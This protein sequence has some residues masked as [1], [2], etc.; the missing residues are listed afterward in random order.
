MEGI[1]V[2]CEPFIGLA[3]R[4]E[5]GEKKNK[6]KKI[7]KKISFGAYQKKKKKCSSNRVVYFFPTS[8]SGH[9]CRVYGRPLQG[10]MAQVI[11][12]GLGGEEA[13]VRYAGESAPHRQQE[14]RQ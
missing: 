1:A 8:A 9:F 5:V 7:I 11:S 12:A 6:I 4:E 3:D 2:T 10:I 13:L 14:R